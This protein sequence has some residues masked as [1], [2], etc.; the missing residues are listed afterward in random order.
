M[1][2]A[3]IALT[4]LLSAAAGAEAQEVDGRSA[5]QIDGRVAD[6]LGRMT[7]EEKVAQMISLWEDKN[8]LLDEQGRFVPA[9]A[10]ELIPYGIG[11]IARP[12]DNFGRTLPGVDTTG[13]IPSRTPRETVELVNAIQRYLVEETRLGIPAMMH[14]E[15]LHG[16]Q[17]RDATVFPQAIALAA[18]W[19]PELVERVYSVVAR[20]IR[21][22]GARQALTPVVDV[23]RDPRWGRIEET[24]GEDPHLV[25]E[26]GLA[27][28][29]GFQ[30]P[31]LPLAEGKVIATLKHM[32]GHGEPE[33]G[34][35]IGPAN[36]SERVLRE[37]FFPPFERAVEEAGV[38]SVM[39]SYNE[40][41]GV[42]SHANGWLLTDVLRG[43]WGF[44]GYVVADY[45]AIP[46]LVDLHHVAATLED[47]AV[48]ALVAGVD[49]ELPNPAAYPRLVELVR[50]GRVDEELVDRSVARLL[51]GK[52]LAGLFD[53]PYA[54]PD[55]AEAL[56]GND[57][58]RALALEAAE[59]AAILLRNEGGLLP[60]DLSKLERI[61]I[62]GPNADETIL[63]GYTDV[64]RQTVSLLDGVRAYVGDRA[65]VVFAPGVRI[66]E[67]RDWWAD[68][69]TLADRAENLRM[70]ATAVEVARG[71]DVVVLAIG[72]NEQTSREAWAA[73][74]LGDRSSLDL[75]G[76]QNELV[77]A[78]AE[79][80]VPTV[81]VLIHGR[82]LSVTEVAESVPA[83]LDAWYLGQETGTA[84]A[85]LLFGEVNPGGK[86]PVTIPRSAG[87][88]PMF[89]NHKPTARR[90]YLF[91]T[92][93]PLWPFG[94]GLSY[95]TFALENLALDRTEMGP[96]ETAVLSVDVVNT[97]EREGDEVVQL[98]V[99]DVVSSVT[100]P[101]RELARFE[102]VSL[103]PGE[104]KRVS[105]SVGPE[106]LRFYDRE[107]ERVVEPGEFELMVGTG[108]VELE[109]IRL[110]VLEGAPR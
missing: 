48:Q 37:V 33:S 56:T 20:E 93:A 14:E 59:K 65:E 7:L 84:L 100:R 41:D 1:K 35:N 51:R 28:V 73:S 105:F 95:T 44:E 103:S 57:E 89:Y 50:S 4:G 40:I 54:D 55:E 29:R 106:Q 46:Q 92:T 11:Q 67:G 98:Y 77:R 6:L 23:A 13:A 42:P 69:V 12:S 102:R 47:A 64:P 16:F 21:V 52:L 66:T 99:R 8:D 2:T 94:H 36:I 15:G 31:G 101:V 76:E 30:G 45:F 88:L 82:P 107:M 83:I 3:A 109:T 97:G 80:G 72:D 26:M 58:A 27:S 10:R 96:S 39:A 22:R 85:R 60:L 32:T 34:T 19:D 75:V 18:T 108:S 62:I 86:L 81:A 49:I 38:M 74:H 24:Y 9:S 25:A 78:I 90:G 53:D 63:G 110:T 104:R 79:T 43:E 68:Q 61:A 5:S 91:D 87:Q 17:A 70:I 71:A